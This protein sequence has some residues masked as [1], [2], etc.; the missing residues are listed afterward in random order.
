MIR[1]LL[2]KKMF[3]PGKNIIEMTSSK[4]EY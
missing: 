1:I 4:P 3:P 2:Y